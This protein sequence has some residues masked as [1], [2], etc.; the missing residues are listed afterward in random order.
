MTGEQQVSYAVKMESGK[1]V[2]AS[3]VYVALLLALVV[4]ITVL[5][6]FVLLPVV[7][8]IA[9][10]VVFVLLAVAALVA[11]EFASAVA[12]VVL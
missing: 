3:T 11:Q 5:T 10:L 1:C 8:T 7:V 4:I 2:G 12:V 6:A 9:V